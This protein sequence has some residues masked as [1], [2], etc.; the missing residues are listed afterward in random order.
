MYTLGGHVFD[1]SVSAHHLEPFTLS[2]RNTPYQSSKLN[3]TRSP[4]PDLQRGEARAS[5][6][7]HRII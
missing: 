4:G 3:L 1:H 6:W 2:S 5:S 7:I